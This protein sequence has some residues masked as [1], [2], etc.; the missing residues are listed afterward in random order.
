MLVARILRRRTLRG[1]QRT[2]I[3]LALSA[4]GALA[5]GGVHGSAPPAAQPAPKHPTLP[6]PVP[7]GVRPA[8]PLKPSEHV[9]VLRDA[10][11]GKRALGLTVLQE[12]TMAAV[13]AQYR[14]TVT[15]Y[16]TRL[17]AMLKAGTSSDTRKPVEDSLKATIALEHA[18]LDSLITPQQKQRMEAALRDARV[19][20]GVSAKH[21]V[22]VAGSRSTTAAAPASLVPVPSPTAPKP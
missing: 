13:R 2:V 10:E 9:A 15:A 6:A 11:I 5:Q 19:K 21:S 7:S 17:N 12:Q 1:V 4:S 16:V 20:A 18:A 8:P 22:T 14:P 3:A